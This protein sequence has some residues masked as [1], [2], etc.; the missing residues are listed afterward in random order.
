MLFPYESMQST[1]Q[2][3]YYADEEENKSR[4]DFW[5]STYVHGTGPSTLYALPP[6]LS[7]RGK[8]YYTHTYLCTHIL[9]KKTMNCLSSDNCKELSWLSDSL[10]CQ[11]FTIMALPSHRACVEPTGVSTSTK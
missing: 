5:I 6:I 3:D 1:A 11:W 8:N 9:K 4:R 10:F 2:Y 7:P